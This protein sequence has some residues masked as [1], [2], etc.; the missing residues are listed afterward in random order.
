MNLHLK[1]IQEIKNHEVD[2]DQNY[3]TNTQIYKNIYR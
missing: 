3:Q 1:I 2:S